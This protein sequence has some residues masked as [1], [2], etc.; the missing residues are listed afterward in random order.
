[1]ELLITI[2]DRLARTSHDV[3]L[4][5]SPT[6]R[7]GDVEPLLTQFVDRTAVWLIDGRPIRPDAPLVS[8]GL[9]DGA[10]LEAGNGTRADA[11]APSVIIAPPVDDPT[12]AILRVVGGPDVGSTWS[13]VPGTYTIGRSKNADL[14]LPTDDEVSR[15]HARLR[16]TTADAIIEDLGSSNGTI[17][18]GTE[19]K[20][21]TTISP[22]GYLKLGNSRAP[23]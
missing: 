13:L 6:A 22:G 18:D 23:R 9:C 1:V 21:A 3:V 4:N 14:A 8:A 12:I 5:M 15:Q 7:L 11:D 20:S 19:I 10:I 16:V 17:V 2:S